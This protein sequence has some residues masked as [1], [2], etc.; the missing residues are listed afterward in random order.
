MYAPTEDK[1]KE[2]KDKFYEQL[3]ILCEKVPKHETLVIVGDVNAK[4]GKEEYIEN[5]AGKETL[6]SRTNDNGRRICGLAAEMNMAIMSTKF[7]HKKEHK[8]TWI[9]PGK[10]TGNQ[11][12]HVLI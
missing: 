10:T 1:E 2:E 6:H 8:V 9:I 11:I 4:I 3:E 5:V 12:D 7:K